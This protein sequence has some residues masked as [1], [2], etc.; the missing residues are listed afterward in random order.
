MP[1]TWKIAAGR[2]GK[3]IE[4]FENL[5][6]VAIGWNEMGDVTQVADREALH[7]LHR[8]AYPEAS[9][10]KSS[11]QVSQVA[12]FLFDMQPGDDVVSYNPGTREYLVGKIDGPASYRHDQIERMANV[13]PVKWLGKVNRDDLTDKTKYA[14]GGIQT[15]YVLNEDA[16][17]EV[18]SLLKGDKPSVEEDNDTAGTALRAELVE[19]AH[20]F[21]KDE[22]RKLEWDQL[23]YLVAGV[24]RAMGYKTMVSEPGP[25][26]GKDIVAS[27]DGLGLEN[28]RIRVEVKHRA[29]TAMG[30]PDIR[31]F[32]GALR[33]GDKGLYVSTGGFTKEARYEAERAT[34]PVT[35]VDLSLL[36]EFVVEHYEAMDA[37][38]RALVPLKRI[39]WPVG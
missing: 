34:V 19:Q 22:V 14:L 33:Q 5:G 6:C 2:G 36:V 4:D 1:T 9:E 30:A 26:L 21:I 18:S 11:V 23:Q 7:R 32:L 29:Q 27:P 13:R 28:P 3:Y 35:L 37:E 24:L 31:S 20:E 38:A 39:Y 8:D 17:A 10:R 16:W 15:L 12:R 25:D